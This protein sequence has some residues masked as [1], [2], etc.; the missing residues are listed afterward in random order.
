[1]DMLNSILD[2]VRDVFPDFQMGSFSNPAQFWAQYELALYNH[3][4]FRTAFTAN[5]FIIIHNNR[6]H[7]APAFMPWGADLPMTWSDLVQYDGRLTLSLP[8]GHESLL[9]PT[10]T[11]ASV[12]PL[13]G[14]RLDL[15]LGVN[16]A[17]QTI[18][19]Q[20]NNGYTFESAIR[21]VPTNIRIE[22]YWSNDG[23]QLGMGGLTPE[24]RAYRLFNDEFVD[25]S[26]ILTRVGNAFR[27]NTGLLSVGYHTFRFGSM[28]T[29]HVVGVRDN[30]VYVDN[31]VAFAEF[32][33]EF[34]D[35][36]H[37]A[38]AD[39]RIV[40]DGRLEWTH[41]GTGWSHATA[42]VSVRRAGSDDF[43]NVTT[44]H[45]SMWLEQAQ[46]NFTPGTNTIRVEYA[47]PWFT[48]QNHVL[49]RQTAAPATVNL[50]V[51]TLQR[52]APTNIHMTPGT[53]THTGSD[54]L[55]WDSNLPWHVI[56]SRVYAR[57]ETSTLYTFLGTARSSIDV[58]MFRL[59]AAG[60]NTFRI[61]NTAQNVFNG[62]QLTI[63]TDSEPT[64]FDVAIVQSTPPPPTN[65]R[66]DNGTI[67]WDSSNVI[68][69]FNTSVRRAGSNTFAHHGSGGGGGSFSPSHATTFTPGLNTIRVEQNSSA[70]TY[71]AG[72]FTVY[73]G[74]GYATFDVYV[75]GA[76]MP[77]IENL[78]LDNRTFRWD[79][80][81]PPMMTFITHHTR[82]Y[83]Q[84]PGSSEWINVSSWSIQEGHWAP[85]P[86][87]TI[88]HTG[89]HR[90]RVVIT[91]PMLTFTDGEFTVF[92]GTSTAEIDFHWS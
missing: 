45:G 15:T 51:T 30:R 81:R 19:L 8:S 34:R 61:I 41:P 29:G 56:T 17:R 6:A 77:P 84:R 12:V 53:W 4:T 79:A 47:T 57:H 87:E 25:A 72:T 48:V 36:Q 50:T 90:A 69:G 65:F 52:P 42:D 3:A 35:T 85:A 76:E 46:F 70:V 32:T 68:S 55:R 13:S 89:T 31:A 62:N 92:N 67:R 78:R 60:N 49:T 91:G 14:G 27:I 38:P 2:D 10:Y 54:V 1:M 73:S 16:N 18:R 11:Y 37:P 64:F 22:G 39:L 20:R 71:A 59:L 88:L 58:A 43:V 26:P 24:T 5:R 63:Y 75:N 9:P 33:M 40:N 44:G 74:V 86:W 21:P 23:P 83:I 66:I 82:L 28:G 80:P 7:F